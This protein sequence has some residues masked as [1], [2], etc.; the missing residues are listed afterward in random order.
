MN[1]RNDWHNDPW[2]DAPAHI[3]IRLQDRRRATRRR[4]ASITGILTL[5]AAGFAWLAEY[6]P[7][8]SLPLLQTH[9]P[10]P[11]IAP[12]ASTGVPPLEHTVARATA[13][14]SAATPLP[15]HLDECLRDDNMLDNRVARCRFGNTARTTLP[16]TPPAK[17]Q[18][19]VS[20]EYLAR[21]RAERDIRPIGTKTVTTEHT[22]HW[23]ERGDGKSY[24]AEWQVRS[25]RIDYGSVCGNHRQGSIEY[26]ECRKAAKQWYRAE[27]RRWEKR[28]END[29]K[30]W[31]RQMQ[32]RYCSAAN[33]FSPMG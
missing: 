14:P 24:L 32:E 25:N 17:P 6:G 33:G 23:V 2:G 31:S 7:D 3:R 21:Y 13:A 11:A 8:S 1:R 15:K 16:A 10:A 20:A 26:R 19:M 18:G 29:G 12:A 4:V 9:A 22:A 28:R 5:L 30:D 27:C